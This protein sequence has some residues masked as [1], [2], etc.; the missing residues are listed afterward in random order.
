CNQVVGY[1]VPS[2]YGAGGWGTM[3]TFFG[4]T[5]GT[6]LAE[7]WFLNNQF[8][9]HKTTELNP[10]LLEVQFNDE[11][12]SAGSII[13]QLYR[14]RISLNNQ[15]AQDTMGLVHDRDVV[16]FYGDPAWRAQLDESHSQAPYRIT[17][18]DAK[19]FTI[20]A[21]YDTKERCAV[22]FPTA[23]TGRN[24]T[25]CTAPE[26]V[27]TNDFIL[28]PKLELKKGESLTVEVK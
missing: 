1:T 26:A 2:W 25:G 18:E 15:T 21:N 24:A 4:N 12:F 17:W 14:A 13:S 23:E 3:G 7:A 19:H 16:A 11:S 27:F 6:S 5:A 10:R 22:W 8:I 20:T 28:F 9:L